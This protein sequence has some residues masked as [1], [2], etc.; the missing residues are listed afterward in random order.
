MNDLPPHEF[1]CFAANSM[2]PPLQS[3]VW[4]LPRRD[5]FFL[6]TVVGPSKKWT[7]HPTLERW[8]DVQSGHK[9]QVS[10]GCLKVCPLCQLRES[11]PSAIFQEVARRTRTKD[12]SKERKEFC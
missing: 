4:A 11:A 12:G 3:Q 5:C 10:A 9:F 2:V 8:V 7:G 1:A 6:P